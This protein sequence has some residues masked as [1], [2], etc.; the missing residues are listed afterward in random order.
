MVSLVEHIEIGWNWIL[1]LV[2]LSV[3]HLFLYEMC[4]QLSLKLY[5]DLCSKA[6]KGTSPHVCLKI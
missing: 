1:L 4:I 5:S 6:P 3:I 2:G